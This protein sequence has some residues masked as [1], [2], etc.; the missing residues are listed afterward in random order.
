MERS[1][2]VRYT[3]QDLLSMPENEPGRHEVL[4]G[5]L[6]VT[7][8]PRLNHQ[9]VARDLGTM[10]HAIARE[11]GLGEVVGPMTVHVHDEMVFQPDLIFIPADRMEIA[12]PEGHVHGV[13]DLAIEILSPST[14][15]YDR[16]LKRKHYVSSGLPELWLVDIDARAVEV[17]RAGAD[18]PVTVRDALTWQVG[19][20]AIELP[21]EEVFQSV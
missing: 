1:S 6:Y 9:R 4:D 20:R 3:Y 14:R 19:D 5:N 11:G 17:W 21:L 15:S 10:M 2:A 8:G 13:P 12:D 16:S 7:P 18:E